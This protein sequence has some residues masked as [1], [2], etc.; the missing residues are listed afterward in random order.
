VAGAGTYLT[1]RRQS[2][3][4]LLGVGAAARRGRRRHPFPVSV[5]AFL[6]AASNKI[7]L[8]RDHLTDLDRLR[9][10][11]E[12][13]RRLIQ[14]AFEGIIGNG[15]SAGDQ[16]AAALA[17]ALGRDLGR[18]NTPRELL[19]ILDRDTA[20]A[21]GD[22]ARCIELLRGW[23]EEPIVRDARERRNLA[24]HAHYE[25]RPCKLHL[26]WLLD[27]VTIRNQPS[28]YDGSLEIHSYCGAF[29]AALAHLEQMVDCLREHG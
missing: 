11:E 19:R 6:E 17:N 22:V 18:R 29:A 3:A 10:G 4:V 8:A 2:T 26:T 9:A 27:S 14:S 21:S 20:G 15:I 5:S 16:S 25:K 12:G 13:E 28:P 1:R 23:A 24:V 7:A